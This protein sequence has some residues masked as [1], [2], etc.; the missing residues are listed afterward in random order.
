MVEWSVQISPEV[1]NPKP[2]SMWESYQE[3]LRICILTADTTPPSP[4]SSAAGRPKITLH[5]AEVSYTNRRYH[6]FN[7]PLGFIF[8]YKNKVSQSIF[9]C[10]WCK[11]KI[12]LCVWKRL[13][14]AGQWELW[15]KLLHLSLT[16]IN[17]G[18]TIPIT[19]RQLYYVF[20]RRVGKS[21]RACRHAQGIFKMKGRGVA[22]AF[23]SESGKLRVQAACP[24]PFCS[25]T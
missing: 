21:S 1:P 4:H 7:E 2:Q 22:T 25:S 14:S 13:P 17:I 15:L 11:Y 16:D 5:W 19:E 6:F 8:L 12:S 3:A 18:F 20:D 9:W 24:I 10:W 23:Q